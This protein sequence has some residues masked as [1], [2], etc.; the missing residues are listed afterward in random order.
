MMLAA[1]S[2]VATNIAEKIRMGESGDAQ[3]KDLME[4]MVV[5]RNQNSAA[6][7]TLRYSQEFLNLPQAT[8][9]LAQ[10]HKELSETERITMTTLMSEGRYSGVVKFL[11]SRRT[12]KGGRFWA[13][14]QK[15]LPAY[16]Y[17][18]ILSN[19]QTHQRNIYS[20]GSMLAFDMLPGQIGRVGADMLFSAAQGR[21]RSVYLRELGPML[22]AGLRGLPNAFK[23]AK[24]RIFLQDVFIKDGILEH[25]NRDWHTKT[26]REIGDS[27]TTLMDVMA[28]STDSKVDKAIGVAVGTVPRMLFGADM[29]FK[30]VAKDVYNAQ[31]AARTA[32]WKRRGVYDENLRRWVAESLSRRQQ[33]G[34]ET[35]VVAGTGEVIETAEL[36][37]RDIEDLLKKN[38]EIFQAFKDNPE[39]LIRTAAEEY[40]E[41][42]TFQSE[43]GKMTKQ[44][45]GF[46]DAFDDSI[47]LPI[48]RWLFIPFISTPINV[49]KRGTELT[50][51]LGLAARRWGSSW[52]EITANQIV[53]GV[54]ALALYQMFK[55]GFLTGP[56]PEDDRE[57]AAFLRAGGKPYAVQFKHASGEISYWRVPE[58]FNIPFVT[59]GN[60][61]YAYDKAMDAENEVEALEIASH[62]IWETFRFMGKNVFFSGLLNSFGPRDQW[63][64]AKEPKRK[65]QAVVPYAGFLR[66]VAET[67]Q[68]YEEGRV[69]MKDD[70]FKL[71]DFATQER[72]L[73][74][75]LM[76]LFGDSIPGLRKQLP[77]RLNALGTPI[78]KRQIP[79]TLPQGW[80]IS[81][82]LV[83]D[84]SIAKNDPLEQ[85]F[86]EADAYPSPTSRNMSINN[87]KIE[88]TEEQHLQ[89]NLRYG[90]LI[91]EMVPREAAGFAW[92]TAPQWQKRLRLQ[93]V[94]SAARTRTNLDLRR[95]YPDLFKKAAVTH[96]GETFRL[97]LTP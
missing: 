22:S 86:F 15:L 48:A 25:K 40:M 71:S 12:T 58:P 67:Q 50:P 1:S 64:F 9:L 51:I 88:L 34:K 61:F 43:P 6:G 41:L 33:T 57:Y 2:Q 76:K 17:M 69:T 4:K 90:M 68:M 80:L 63:D 75:G 7:R 23:V 42:I 70:N 73:N 83:P 66:Y 3:L 87:R 39:M 59:L 95:T 11:R 55:A 81:T 62:V 31:F 72:T 53:A 96:P 89:A 8:V 14:M 13:K 24:E 36:T 38:P 49:A 97:P 78:T 91:R 93:K 44:L 77:D 30:M 5:L 47:G 45:I 92:K 82:S 18:N 10:L 19:P 65:A 28:L 32:E 52:K 21:S 94:L 20:T 37:E 26:N 79:E 29:F 35:Q 60:L 56:P 27:V 46:R 84:L 85:I 74:I 16:L 54:G